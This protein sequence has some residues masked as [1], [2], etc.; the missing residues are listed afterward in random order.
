MRSDQLSIRRARKNVCEDLS[1]LNREMALKLL[2]LAGKTG[3]I[4]PLIEAV[5]A[6]RSSEEYYSQD[7]AKIELA[8]IQRKLGDVLL[9]VGKKEANQQALNAAIEAY[10]GAITIA[11]LLGDNKLRI[12][13]RKNYNQALEFAGKSGTTKH[14]S[15][16]GVA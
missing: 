12:S 10:R 3:E 1:R 9:S 5:R 14:L 8:H 4:E 15:L 7:N 13:L 6:L 11:S 16:M 2:S